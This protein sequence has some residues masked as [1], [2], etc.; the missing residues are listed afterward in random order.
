[1]QGGRQ[2]AQGLRGPRKS[3]IKQAG[4]KEAK[5]KVNFSEENFGLADGSKIHAVLEKPSLTE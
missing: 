3:A 2:K 1:V 4:K 5:S